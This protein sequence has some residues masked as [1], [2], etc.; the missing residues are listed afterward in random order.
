MA[1]KMTPASRYVCG[2]GLGLLSL[3]G[4]LELLKNALLVTLEI[5]KRRGGGVVEIRPARCGS[6]ELTNCRVQGLRKVSVEV[7]IQCVQSGLERV[8]LGQSLRGLLSDIRLSRLDPVR[9]GLGE[10]LMIQRLRRRERAESML[11]GGHGMS[12]C[13]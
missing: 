1:F 9:K 13:G 12:V 7:L 4:L 10:S 6:R 8:V 5:G 3:D 11:A 2:C